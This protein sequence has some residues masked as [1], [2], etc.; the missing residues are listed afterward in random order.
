MKLSISDGNAYMDVTMQE[1]MREEPRIGA[2]A[3]RLVYIAD[4]KRSLSAFACNGRE[5][6]DRGSFADLRRNLVKMVNSRRCQR[7]EIWIPMEGLERSGHK[8]K[9]KTVWPCC[10]MLLMIICDV[11]DC[12]WFIIIVM[13]GHM[14]SYFSSSSLCTTQSTWI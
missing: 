10:A 2:E 1:V 14:V 5:R 12:E 3:V 8:E 13:S 4:R 7:G 11:V 9:R 6:S